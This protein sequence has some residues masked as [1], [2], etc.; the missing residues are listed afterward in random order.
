[1]TS[2]QELWKSPKHAGNL[3]EHSKQALDYWHSSDDAAQ[4]RAAPPY[5]V[6]CAFQRFEVWEAGRFPSAPRADFTLDK[7]PENRPAP[8]WTAELEG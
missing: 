4:N 8:V 2:F 7:L 3:A 6:V 5:V 1:M